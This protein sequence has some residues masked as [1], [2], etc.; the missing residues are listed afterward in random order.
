MLGS[1]DVLWSLDG[2]GLSLS[3]P[4]E[5]PGLVWAAWAAASG[6]K[7]LGYLTADTFPCKRL[8]FLSES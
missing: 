4:A 3:D 6:E 7:P 8:L 1:G 2:L 5:Q